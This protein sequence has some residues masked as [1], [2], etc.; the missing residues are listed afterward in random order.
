MVSCRSRCGSSMWVGHVCQ[1]TPHVHR[2]RLTKRLRLHC[3]HHVLLVRVSWLKA[4]LVPSAEWAQVGQLSRT[5]LGNG[6]LVMSGGLVATVLA[7]SLGRVELAPPLVVVLCD[8]G[9]A[10][11]V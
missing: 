8:A 11:G 9:C 10:A 4:A 3:L 7:K 1:G 6:V 2:Q 5:M